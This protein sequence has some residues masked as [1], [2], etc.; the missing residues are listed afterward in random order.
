MHEEDMLRIAISC[1]FF[2]SFKTFS[3]DII[4]CS[5]ASSSDIFCAS[6]FIWLLLS[7]FTFRESLI[8]EAVSHSSLAAF[9]FSNNDASNCSF[10]IFHALFASSIIFSM[11]TSSCSLISS[12]KEDKSSEDCTIDTNEDSLFISLEI[13][14]TIIFLVLMVVTASSYFSISSSVILSSF[15]IASRSVF[16][17]YI[18]FSTESF[19]P[20]SEIWFCNCF[21]LSFNLTISKTVFVF[22]VFFLFNVWIRVSLWFWSLF[23]SESVRLSKTLS[24]SSSILVV[25]WL[26]SANLFR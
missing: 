25:S 11:I 1:F 16:N 15:A 9:C 13:S 2:S 14:S 19:P 24:T 23:P 5:I 26:E 17:R 7:I 20:S 21:I 8:A 18:S 3:F 4:A 22:S 6:S 10:C 12:G